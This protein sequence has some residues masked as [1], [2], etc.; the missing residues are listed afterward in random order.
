[1]NQEITRR[2]HKYFSVLILKKQRIP[3]KYRQKTG[4][5]QILRLLLNPNSDI[6]V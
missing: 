1:M 2:I 5:K 6:L 3:R 4:Y